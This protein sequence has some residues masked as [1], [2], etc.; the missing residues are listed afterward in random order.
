VE[1]LPIFEYAIPNFFQRF[2]NGILRKWD[3]FYLAMIVHVPPPFTPYLGRMAPMLQPFYIGGGD[4]SWQEEKAYSFMVLFFGIKVL[5]LASESAS[6]HK[7][8]N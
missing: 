5:F 6:L 1:T 7:Y 3:N 4:S 8:T 2:E